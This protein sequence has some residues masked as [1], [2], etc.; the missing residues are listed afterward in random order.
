M[1][2]I[3]QHIIKGVVGNVR[4]NKVGERAVANFSV[5]T[6]FEYKAKDGNWSKE[7]TWHNV[8]AW[9][10]YG[11]CDLE[12][13]DK[14]CTVLV[15]GRARTRKYTGNDGQEREVNEILAESLDIIAPEKSAN[16]PVSAAGN[17]RGRVDED[18][19]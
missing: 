5:V 16:K 10:G 3:N 15:V 11:I 13:L 4:V 9:K 17:N 12:S 19:F 8:S 18:V 14:G 1:K 2:S 6:E 7:A